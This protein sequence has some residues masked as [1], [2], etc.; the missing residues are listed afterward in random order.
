MQK[1]KRKRKEHWINS[2][3]VVSVLNSC[4]SQTF[5]IANW[6]LEREAKPNIKPII[7]WSVHENGLVIIVLNVT[8]DYLLLFVIEC[9]SKDW[10][11]DDQWIL[12][13]W[14]W[15]LFPSFFVCNICTYV[16]IGHLHYFEV[17]DH[18][19]YHSRSDSWRINSLR[20]DGRN[21]CCS[22]TCFFIVSYAIRDNN[23]KIKIKMNEW[24]K[25][26][27]TITRKI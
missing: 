5:H 3:E 11:Q 24:K 19:Y 14:E 6:K 15:S 26:K 21:R 27:T 25:T 17:F 8:Y 4:K 7:I 23:N 18:Y 2:L 20:R 22:L 1:K 13:N 12:M 9:L 10:K 16:F